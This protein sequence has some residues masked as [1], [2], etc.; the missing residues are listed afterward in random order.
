VS[1]YTNFER[2]IKNGLANCSANNLFVG[3]MDKRCMIFKQC[4]LAL[5]YLRECVRLSTNAKFDFLHTLLTLLNAF[6]RHRHAKTLV[7][8]F[9]LFVKSFIID[10]D[11][12]SLTCSSKKVSHERGFCL[13]RKKAIR[14]VEHNFEKAGIRVLLK[15]HNGK[16]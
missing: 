7:I 12:N 8:A 5:H 13:S 9:P 6:P 15:G 3:L 10:D 16:F 4:L 11:C 14:C 1:D 2:T